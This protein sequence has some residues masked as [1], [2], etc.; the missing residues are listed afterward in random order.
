MKNIVTCSTIQ[1]QESMSVL[2]NVDMFFPKIRYTKAE[3]QKR[4]KSKM[5]MSFIGL[6]KDEV[7][8]LLFIIFVRVSDTAVFVTEEEKALI[9]AITS[10]KLL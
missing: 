6:V 9:S 4:I 2:L 5:G 10:S 7:L 8:S 3:I 1:F